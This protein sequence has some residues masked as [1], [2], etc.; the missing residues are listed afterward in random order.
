MQAIKFFLPAESQFQYCT[1]FGISLSVLLD[2]NNESELR[3]IKRYWFLKNLEKKS[4]GAL[5]CSTK[6][7]ARTCVV[8]NSEFTRLRNT[9]NKALQHENFQQGYRDRYSSEH[10]KQE[11]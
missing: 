2:V 1:E 9:V 5:Q 10:C 6:T 8:H 4:R 7:Q 3:V 11:I